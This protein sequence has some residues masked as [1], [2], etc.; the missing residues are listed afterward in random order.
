MKISLSNIQNFNNLDD[1]SYK[2]TSCND[3]IH[4]KR[5]STWTWNKTMVV[6]D[7]QGILHINWQNPFKRLLNPL[8]HWV[9]KKFKISHLSADKN[10]LIDAFKKVNIGVN[11][12]TDFKGKIIRPSLGKWIAQLVVKGP[13]SQSKDYDP[14]RDISMEDFQRFVYF[15]S[16]AKIEEAKELCA[17]LESLDSCF[18]KAIDTPLT[19][20]IKKEAI[21]LVKWLLDNKVNPNLPTKNGQSPLV[22]AAEKDLPRSFFMALFDAGAKPQNQNEA[23]MIIKLAGGRTD[24]SRN[25]R[26]IAAIDALM[27]GDAVDWPDPKQTG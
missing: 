5:T 21:E 3:W 9:F 13:S 14:I 17:K 11:D 19:L 15:M 1:F 26:L 4:Y 10:D 24:I 7:Q 25:Q 2:K 20:S 23:D 22:L 18:E 16:E 27:K 12:S 8:L 6:I